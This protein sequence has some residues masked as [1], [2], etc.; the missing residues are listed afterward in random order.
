[1]DPEREKPAAE[2]ERHRDAGDD[3]HVEILGEQEGDHPGSA[4]LGEVARDEFRIRLHE[5]KG[6]AVDFGE[7]R[8]GKDEEADELRD[9]VPHAALGV[10]DRGQREAAGGDHYTDQREPLR[11]LV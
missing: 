9:E 5:I 10:D 6:R 4:V 1:M 3:H 2:E 11:D 8:D 7:A